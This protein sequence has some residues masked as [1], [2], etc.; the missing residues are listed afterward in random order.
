MYSPQKRPVGPAFALTYRLRLRSCKLLGVFV[1]PPLPPLLLEPVQTAGS[2]GSTDITPLLRYFGPVRHP[3][4]FPRLPGVTGYTVVFL[5]RFRDGTR[6]ASPVARCILVIV[7]SLPPR[8]SVSPHQSVCD[9]PCCLRPINGGSASE[10]KSFGVTY[11]FTF[12]TAQ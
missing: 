10:V 7:L 6:R 9:P 5:R 3:L 12:V 11:A 8:Q 2:L 1:I 4:A